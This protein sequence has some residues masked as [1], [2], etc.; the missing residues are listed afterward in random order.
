MVHG[1]YHP[2]LTGG[3]FITC[4]CNV[5]SV[6]LEKTVELVSNPEYSGYSACFY[7]K[8]YGI[9]GKWFKY[10]KYSGYSPSW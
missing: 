8:T 3:S 5:Y 6:L 2:S 10:C 7:K 9:G 1:T 4:N